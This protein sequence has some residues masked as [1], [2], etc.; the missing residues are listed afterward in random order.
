MWS[1]P[2]Y[3]FWKAHD[4]AAFR[5]FLGPQRRQPKRKSSR[6]TQGKIESLIVYINLN[7]SSMNHISKLPNIY[8]SK[9]ANNNCICPICLD[10]LDECETVSH[11]LCGHVFHERCILGWI[12]CHYS[13]NNERNTAKCPVC[14]SSTTTLFSHKTSNFIVNWKDVLLAWV[15]ITFVFFVGLF[16]GVCCVV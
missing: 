9:D 10:S 5:L 13:R 12:R 2:I 16:F 8:F 11:T 15:M 14:Q 4:A 3:G 7:I 1:H 6:T